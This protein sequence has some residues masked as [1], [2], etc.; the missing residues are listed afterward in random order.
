MIGVNAEYEGRGGCPVDRP[1]VRI[2]VGRYGTRETVWIANV[3]GD[4]PRR[5]NEIHIRSVR[6][7]YRNNRKKGQ[8]EAKDYDR[9]NLIPTLQ[10]SDP[11]DHLGHLWAHIN[12]DSAG[13]KRNTPSR[14]PAKDG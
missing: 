11:P 2:D 1:Y 8:H 10:N 12:R 4:A 13:T 7:G 5:T 9:P 3:K 14:S 6:L